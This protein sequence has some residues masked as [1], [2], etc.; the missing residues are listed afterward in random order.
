MLPSC[1]RDDIKNS[2]ETIE[3]S[4]RKESSVFWRVCCVWLRRTVLPGKT[5]RGATNMWRYRHRLEDHESAASH[6]PGQLHSVYTGQGC[7]SW[8]DSRIHGM[9]VRMLH[10]FTSDS[11]E[12]RLFPAA[13]SYAHTH[14]ASTPACIHSHQIYPTLWLALFNY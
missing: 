2:F 9:P 7:E 12:H 10:D 1:S 5:V 3:K 14:M 6:D 8:L 13:R 4:W 11:L